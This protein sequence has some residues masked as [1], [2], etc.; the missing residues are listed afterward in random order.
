M[1]NYQKSLL[2]TKIDLSKKIRDKLD[3][4]MAEIPKLSDRELLENIYRELIVFLR[5]NQLKDL[6]E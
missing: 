4:Q 3:E 2:E 5:Y 6:E 1:D